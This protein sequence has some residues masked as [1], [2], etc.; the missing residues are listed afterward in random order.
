MA[1]RIIDKDLGYKKILFN[2]NKVKKKP[3]VNVGFLDGKKGN[4]IH[5]ASTFNGEKLRVVD[6]AVTHEYGEGVPNRSFMRST[7]E[8]NFNKWIKESKELSFKIISKDITLKKALSTVGMMIKKDIK[9]KIKKGPFKPLSQLTIENRQI[10]KI[11]GGP[12]PKTKDKPLRDTLQMMNSI[13]S[14]SVV[15]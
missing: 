14:E 7:Y 4:N 2:I 12:S 10:R 5:N 11:N 1:T 6:I 3:Y 8:E 15:K 9:N 13:E